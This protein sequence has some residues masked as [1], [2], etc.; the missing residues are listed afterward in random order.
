MPKSRNQKLKLLYLKQILEYHTDEEHGITT[1]KIHDELQN[2]QIEV[3]RKTVYEDIRSLEDFGLEI[4]HEKFERTYRLL[5]REFDLAEIKLL[6]DSIQS[7][8]F[9]SEKKTWEL[10]EKLKK[11]CSHRQAEQLQGEVIVANRVKSENI[12]IHYNVDEI[13][14]AIS[15]DMQVNFRYYEY[16]INKREKYYKNGGLYSVS[17]WRLIYS[18]DNYYLLGYDEQKK[19]FKHFRIDRMNKVSISEIKRNG[20]EE[21]EKIDM[22]NYSKYTFSM[23]GGEIE[24][25][26]MVFQNRMMSTVMDKFGH[27]I[28]AMKEDNTHFRIVVPVAISQQFF[29]WIFGLGK[30]AR[31]VA[32]ESVK[33]QMKKLLDE[34]SSRYVNE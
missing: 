19:K 2:A 15:E 1:K 12:S 18:D 32:P 7:S 28:V 9:L 16:D 20:R 4:G 22:A 6:I 31:I 5:S 25:V 17:P 14:R 34:I 24:Y 23:F 26:T 33:A 21:F 29:G 10:I 27:D 3:E 30:S 8:K 11:L 13:H